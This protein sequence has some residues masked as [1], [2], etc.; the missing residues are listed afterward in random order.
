MPEAPEVRIITEQLSS[1]IARSTLENIAIL[2]GRF[3][4]TPPEQLDEFKQFLPTK[5]GKIA[6]KGK[7]IWFEFENGWYL[8]NTLGMTGSWS[9]KREKHSALQL[10]FSNKDLFF[11]DIRHFGSVKFTNSA[12]AL[13]SKVSSLGV[14]V[15]DHALTVGDLTTTK[16]LLSTYLCSVF[17]TR[18]KKE[19]LAKILMDQSILAGVGNYIKCESLYRAKLSPWRQTN[20]LTEQEIDALAQA[21]TDVM[22]LS[23]QAGGNTISDYKDLN[24]K[25]GD[26]SS[27]LRV[28]GKVVDP[29]GNPIKREKTQDGRTTHWVPTVQK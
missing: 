14:D 18:L 24:G 22:L 1:F 23:Y 21:I 17:S 13:K 7:F 5:I 10:N 26:F 6:C 9:A 11:T 25:K 2:G 12:R 20:S 28:Y 4:K 29:L 8:F 16:K 3:L 27:F 19:T 15:L